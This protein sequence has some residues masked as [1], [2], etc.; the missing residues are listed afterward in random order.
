MH[1]YKR[2][3]LSKTKKNKKTKLEFLNFHKLKVTVS[4]FFEI[5]SIL[6]EVLYISMIRNL[7]LQLKYLVF[8]FRNHEI[9]NFLKSWKIPNL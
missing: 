9:I 5:P 7:E 1:C 2:S 3:I 8:H 4:F 6:I